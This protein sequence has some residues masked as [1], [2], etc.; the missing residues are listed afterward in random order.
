MKNS[1]P[2]I[3]AWER[4]RDGRGGSD[5]VTQVLSHPEENILGLKLLYF[6][7][8]VLEPKSKAP[9]TSSSSA[10]TKNKRG[11]NTD[12]PEKIQRVLRD[13]SIGKTRDEIYDDIIKSGGVIGKSTVGG[14]LPIMTQSGVLCHDDSRPRKYYLVK[15]P[16]LT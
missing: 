1:N 7:R 6:A 16:A 14:R 15:V 13:T 5:D 10:S 2:T 8:G 9:S 3:A 4:I 11:R 12:A